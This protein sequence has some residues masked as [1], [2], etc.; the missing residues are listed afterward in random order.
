L[1]SEQYRH[2]GGKQIAALRGAHPEPVS[3]IHTEAANSLGIKEGDWLY[4]E[5]KQG[6]IKQKAA[7]STT[8]HPRVVVADYGWWFPERDA[9]DLYGWSESNVNV[10][11]DNK[12]PFN[13]EM[14]S[15]NFRGIGCKVYKAE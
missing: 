3:I 15:P 2:S 7:L 12:P 8:I 11:T 13:Q 9:S 6:E 10:L 4:I 5:T 14:G 1:K